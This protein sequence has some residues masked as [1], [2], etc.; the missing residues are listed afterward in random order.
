M[1]NPTFKQ[2][3]ENFSIFSFE[4]KTM[5]SNGITD[6]YFII[7]LKNNPYYPQLQFLWKYQYGLKGAYALDTRDFNGLFTD[8][9]EDIFEL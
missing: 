8:S 7:N 2:I 5:Y 1:W 9:K 4:D 3:I 6:K